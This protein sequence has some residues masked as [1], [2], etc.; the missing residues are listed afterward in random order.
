MIGN[1]LPAGCP[2]GGDCSGVSTRVVSCPYT[3]NG[4]GSLCIGFSV[5]PRFQIRMSLF[6]TFIAATFL[7]RHATGNW[8]SFFLSPPLA[9]AKGFCA[10][11]LQVLVTDF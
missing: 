9:L 6:E 7:R 4:S 2:G 8:V 5:G 3:R 10:Y 11:K 1:G